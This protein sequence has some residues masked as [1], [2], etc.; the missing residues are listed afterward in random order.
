MTETEQMEARQRQVAEGKIAAEAVF[1]EKGIE[2]PWLKYEAQASKAKPAHRRTATTSMTIAEYEG[3][4][5]K[6]RPAQPKQFGRVTTMSNSMTIAEYE[7]HKATTVAMESVKRNKLKG[8]PRQPEPSGN[9]L[10]G[11]VVRLAS[12]A[13]KT[14]GPVA[15]GFRQEYREVVNSGVSMTCTEDE[16]VAVCV[17]ETNEPS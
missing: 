4:R 3:W 1:R 15:A 2:P 9:P 14:E 7:Q 6:N 17:E 8:L 12:E 10:M 16:Y 5:S 11:P 13:E